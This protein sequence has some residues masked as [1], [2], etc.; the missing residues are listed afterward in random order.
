MQ[1]VAP[2][3]P[4]NTFY[5]GTDYEDA[6]TNCYNSKPCP[7]G[8]QDECPMGMTCYPIVVCQTPPP[9]PSTISAEGM[10]IAT[11]AP[12][13]PPVFEMDLESFTNGNN[14]SGY[15]TVLLLTKSLL[16]FV[17]VLFH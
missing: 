8:G 14:N 12:T 1:P 15:T 4:D 11:S 6:V 10:G 7:E 3:D 2:F 5:C 16:L 13:S 17:A 9:V